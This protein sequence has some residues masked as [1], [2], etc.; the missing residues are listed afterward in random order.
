MPGG[1]EA[2]DSQR[3][4]TEAGVCLLPDNTTP[5]HPELHERWAC[6][7]VQQGRVAPR[8]TVAGDRPALLLRARLWMLHCP[9][10]PPLWKHFF[11]EITVSGSRDRD[12]EML[13]AIVQSIVVMTVRLGKGQAHTDGLLIIK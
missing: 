7:S 3:L 10:N 8:F 13:G 9:L 4:L 5:A 1:R 11:V 12:L 6:Q 2:E